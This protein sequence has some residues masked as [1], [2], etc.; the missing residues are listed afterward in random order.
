[1]KQQFLIIAVSSIVVALEMFVGCCQTKVPNTLSRQPIP[2]DHTGRESGAGTSLNSCCCWSWN[3]AALLWSYAMAT[4]LPV[5]GK[6]TC[7][8]WCTMHFLDSLDNLSFL[9]FPNRFV[10]LSPFRNFLLNSGLLQ[11]RVNLWFVFYGL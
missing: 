9:Q 5:Y 1:M 6:Q 11:K 8:L 7:V 10:S 4:P 3:Y 2:S